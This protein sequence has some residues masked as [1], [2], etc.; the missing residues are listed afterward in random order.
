[1]LVEHLLTN[2]DNAL[3]E[4][5]GRHVALAEGVAAG[6]SGGSGAGGAG[7]GAA[8]ADV[9]GGLASALRYLELPADGA[10]VADASGLSSADALPASTLSRLLVEVARREHDLGVVDDGLAVAGRT[11]TLAEDDRFVDEHPEAVGAIRGKT[12]T[13]DDMVGLAAIAEP[14]DGRTITFTIW[15]EG[16]DTAAATTDD[17]RRQV[18]ALAAGLLAC[19]A[20][21][22]G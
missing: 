22:N 19:G 7:T 15:A 2:S 1:M 8:F 4:A 18:D 20:G 21:V 12:G 17:A 13:L 3:A 16:L 10:V 9:R 6:G 11:G 14:G 5:L